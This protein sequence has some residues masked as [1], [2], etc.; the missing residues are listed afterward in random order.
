MHEIIF[1]F[2]I[3]LLVS[4]KSKAVEKQSKEVTFSTG[5]NNIK[6]KNEM[7]KALSSVVLLL[8]DHLMVCLSSFSG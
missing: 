1:Y 5:R 3:Y 2:T 8:A 7:D 4:S 6:N